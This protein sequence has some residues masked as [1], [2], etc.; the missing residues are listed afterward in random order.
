MG[1]KI[2]AHGE[3][4]EACEGIMLLG[5]PG[6]PFPAMATAG[7]L[8]ESVNGNNLSKLSFVDALDAI[9]GASFPKTLKFRTDISSHKIFRAHMKDSTQVFELLSERYGREDGSL[10][11][12]AFDKVQHSDRVSFQEMDTAGTGRVNLHEWLA[13][14]CAVVTAKHTD[15]LDS[16]DEWIKS[17]LQSLRGALSE[18]AADKHDSTEA[19]GR[20]DTM[21]SLDA[22]M[23][24]DEERGGGQA[25]DDE[26]DFEASG[27]VYGQPLQTSAARSDPR[28]Q[29]PKVL[30][31]CVSWLDDHGVTTPEIWQKAVPVSTLTTFKARYDAA[32]DVEL[33]QGENPHL[34]T[35]LVKKFLNEVPEGLVAVEAIQALNEAGTDVSVFHRVLQGL[36]ECHR[37]TLRLL[38]EHLHMVAEE[39]ANKMESNKLARTMCNAMKGKQTIGIAV[40][41]NFQTPLQHMID[42]YTEVFTCGEDGEESDVSL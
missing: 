10:D 7:M 9:K 22:L 41:K 20:S 26:G 21:D 12:A 35:G 32:E 34:V 24:G 16:G 13:Y 25:D 5:K 38:I 36:E 4:N 8:I 15:E 40:M 11:K 18:S 42:N 17:L 27:P 19:R 29:T 6:L 1:I 31:Q 30:R 3:T 23:A 33:A 28:G 37:E 39:P 14:L 2:V